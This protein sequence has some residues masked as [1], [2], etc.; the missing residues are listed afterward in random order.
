MG[1]G[2][3]TINSWPHRVTILPRSNGSMT[4]F[5]DKNR[6]NTRWCL[7]MR[8]QALNMPQLWPSLLFIPLLRLLVPLNQSHTPKLLSLKYRPAVS[9]GRLMSLIIPGIYHNGTSGN[10]GTAACV[11]HAHRDTPY[12]AHLCRNA[13]CYAGSALLHLSGERL[14]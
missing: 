3:H 12:R 13:C 6:G 11:I 5:P 1:G 8:I 4:D 2:L 9:A 14:L 7:F 10:L